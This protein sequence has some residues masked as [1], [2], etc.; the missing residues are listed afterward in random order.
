META[1][2]SYNMIQYSGDA[3]KEVNKMLLPWTVSLLIKCIIQE[4][5]K[6]MHHADVLFWFKL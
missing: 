3:L 1:K 5:Y 6:L 4:E 2:W